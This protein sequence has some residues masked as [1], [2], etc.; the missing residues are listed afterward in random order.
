MLT[1]PLED[2][3]RGRHLKFGMKMFRRRCP[4]GLQTVVGNC[5]FEVATFIYG[6]NIVYHNPHSMNGERQKGNL[7]VVMGECKE[8][9]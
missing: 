5:Y 6:N 2:L 1:R 9:G 4:V 7:A 3:Q 8:G